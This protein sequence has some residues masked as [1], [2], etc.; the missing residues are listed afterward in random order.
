MA[1]AVQRPDVEPQVADTGFKWMTK[2]LDWI[3]EEGHPVRSGVRVAL[4]VMLLA[5]IAAIIAILI[6]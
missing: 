4:L 2:H 5:P 3:I 1:E 6:H